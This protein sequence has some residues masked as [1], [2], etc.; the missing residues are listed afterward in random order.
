MNLPAADATWT[1]HF[2]SQ[3]SR[4]DIT[5]MPRNRRA[6]GHLAVQRRDFCHPLSTENS[7]SRTQLYAVHSCTRKTRLNGTQLSL[8]S[9]QTLPCYDYLEGLFSII[10]LFLILLLR[11]HVLQRRVP[12]ET[13][14]NRPS[15][16]ICSFLIAAFYASKVLT[17]AKLADDTQARV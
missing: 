8:A 1:L 12:K 9:N 16:L 3:R 15:I 10:I 5:S 13:R 14:D 4:T 17:F 2:R 11:P 7:C 6:V